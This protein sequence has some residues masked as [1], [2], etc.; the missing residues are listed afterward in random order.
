MGACLYR[1]CPK[2]TRRKELQHLLNGILRM[3]NRAAHAKRL[4]NPAAAE[5]SSLS[6]VSDAMS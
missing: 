4:F 2:G 3:R 6:A 5:L 1:A